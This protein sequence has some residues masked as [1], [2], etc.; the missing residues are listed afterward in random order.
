[1]QV[2]I[3]P[4]VESLNRIK[5]RGRTNLLSLFELRPP[6]SPALR[7]W[8]PLFLS[9]QIVNLIHAF[10]P[11]ILRTLESERDLTP[12]APLVVSPLDSD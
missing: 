1:M 5:G 9:I 8:H 6:S 7:N 12:L 3:N 11:P 2:I 4:S 10:G